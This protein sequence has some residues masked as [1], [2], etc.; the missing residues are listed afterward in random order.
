[1]HLQKSGRGALPRG[2]TCRVGIEGQRTVAVPGFGDVGYGIA[3]NLA[4]SPEDSLLVALEVEGLGPRP[5]DDL[6]WLEPEERVDSLVPQH[7]VLV[8]SD[9]PAPESG[10]LLVAGRDPRGTGSFVFWLDLDPAPTDATGRALHERAV[11]QAAVALMAPII[12]AETREARKSRLPQSAERQAALDALASGTGRRTALI[13]LAASAD[14]Q[15]VDDFAL[16]ADDARLESFVERLRATGS[17]EGD[18]GWRLE[19]VVYDE[20]IEL[21]LRGQLPPALESVLLRH[22]GEVGRFPGLMD[23]LLEE[24]T[25]QEDL[26]TLLVWENRQ[27]LRDGNPASRVRALDW[28]EERGLAPEGFDPLAV[29]SARI[30]VLQSLAPEAPE[31]APE[32]E[33]EE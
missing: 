26:R 29:P 3:L 14:A 2:A 9:A 25:D 33:S 22:T 28:L 8:L 5:I 10:T 30:A 31:A 4:R 11:A 16:V 23:D 19:Q 6:A 27:F 12:A 15:A 18:L 21:S 1:M 7:E 24:S 13:I 20:L 17:L 32:A